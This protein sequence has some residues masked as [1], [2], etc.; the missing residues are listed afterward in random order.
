MKVPSYVIYKAISS[1]IEYWLDYHK[2]QAD[3]IINLNKW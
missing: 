3:T 1:N 2:V